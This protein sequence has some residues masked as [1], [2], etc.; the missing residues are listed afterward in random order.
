MEFLEVFKQFNAKL[1]TSLPMKDVVFL[2]KLNAKDLFSGGLKAQVKAI[3]TATERADYFLDNK[4]EKDLINSNNSSFLQL[5]SVME[6][7]N[8]SLKMLATEIR[9]KLQIHILMG[10]NDQIESVSVTGK[11]SLKL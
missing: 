2:A 5:L 10:V 7:Y 6:E 1:I 8:E 4:I 9:G 11:C 3:S